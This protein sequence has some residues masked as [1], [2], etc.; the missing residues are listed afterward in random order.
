HYTNYRS[1]DIPTAV[2]FIK[3]CGDGESEQ[4][5][6]YGVEGVFELLPADVSADGKKTL[7][8][9][10]TSEYVV[11]LLL[12][13]QQTKLKNCDT[14]DCN[15]KGSRLDFTVKP[16]LVHIDLLTDGEESDFHTLLLK[17]YAVPQYRSL[18]SGEALLSGFYDLVDDETLANLEQNLLRAWDRYAV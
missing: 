7:S 4:W 10:G 11:M 8:A 9:L 18:E 3:A 1:P 5:P 16:L 2:D 14:N 12:E 15:E 13:T 6:I 17:R